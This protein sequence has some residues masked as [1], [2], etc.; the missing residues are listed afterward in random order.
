MLDEIA[1]ILS[2]SI[3][4]WHYTNMHLQVPHFGI[5]IHFKAERTPGKLVGPLQYYLYVNKVL[6]QET[7]ISIN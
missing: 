1:D 4:K 3:P 6:L 2:F 5:L 7:I